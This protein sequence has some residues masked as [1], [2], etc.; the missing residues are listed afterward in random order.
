MRRQ[1]GDEF[2][3]LG[4]IDAVLKET[5]KQHHEGENGC[6]KS[7]RGECHD[8]YENIATRQAL[9]LGC[10]RLRVHFYQSGRR[11]GGVM[12]AGSRSAL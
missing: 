5:Q 4:D 11:F 3:S 10:L 8:G 1:A 7:D 9:R 2:V 12:R 6:A